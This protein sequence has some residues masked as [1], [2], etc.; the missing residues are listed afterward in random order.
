MAVR[1]TAYTTSWCS[2]CA[3]SKR[4][5]QRRGMSFEEIDI[6]RTAGAE[7]AMRA[8]N[9]NSGKVPTIVIEQETER[10]VL[11]EPT[12]RELSELLCNLP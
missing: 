3:R 6:E 7:E 10:T 8:L 9:G 11:I 4:L 1:I 12:D 2:D 5:L